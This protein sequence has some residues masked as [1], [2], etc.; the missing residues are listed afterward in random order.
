M[1]V[2]LNNLVSKDL[3]TR[4]AMDAITFDKT[5]NEIIESML[6]YFLRMTPKKRLQIYNDKNHRT[7]IK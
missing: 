4:V 3:K 1:K 7:T 2:Q 6:A 5:Q